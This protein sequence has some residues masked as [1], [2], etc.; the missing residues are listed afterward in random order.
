MEIYLR[1]S[2]PNVQLFN[3][4]MKEYKKQKTHANLKL[5]ENEAKDMYTC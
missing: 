1:F 3:T 2:A 5:L 4:R